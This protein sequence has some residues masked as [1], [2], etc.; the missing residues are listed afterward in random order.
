[1]CEIGQEPLNAAEDVV[2]CVS[3]CVLHKAKVLEQQL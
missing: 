1:M 3:L 2:G